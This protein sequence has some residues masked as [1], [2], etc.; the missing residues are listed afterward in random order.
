MGSM[1]LKFRT[2]IYE[3]KTLINENDLTWLFDIYNVAVNEV[4]EPSI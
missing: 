1:T 2:N 3:I 4:Q